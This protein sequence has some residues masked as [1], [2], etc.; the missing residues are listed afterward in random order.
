MR[1]ALAFLIALM[2]VGRCAIFGVVA[3]AVFWL[4]RSGWWFLVAA[5][6]MLLLPSEFSFTRTPEASK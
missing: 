2:I 3:Y 5:A 6:F 1:W 4:D